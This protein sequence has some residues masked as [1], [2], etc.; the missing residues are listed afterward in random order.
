MNKTQ[1]YSETYQVLKPLGFT[2][3]D[4]ATL[5]RAETT[6]TRL[7]ENECNGWP[8]WRN[9]QMVYDW[10]EAQYKKEAAQAERIAQRIARLVA[11]TSGGRVTVEFGGDPRGCAIHLHLPADA[12]GHKVYNSWD[13]ESWVLDW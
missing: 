9:G 4:I 8:T 5:H 2:H 12:D 11:D 13:G 1:A 6:L 10:N 7:N 3:A